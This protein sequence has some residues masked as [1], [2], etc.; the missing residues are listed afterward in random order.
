MKI[1]IIYLIMLVKICDD[2]TFTVL[3]LLRVSLKIY[4]LTTTIKRN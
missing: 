1:I 2:T 3:M 4:L